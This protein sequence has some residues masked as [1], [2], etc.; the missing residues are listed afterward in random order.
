MGDSCRLSLFSLIYSSNKVRVVKPTQAML[1]IMIIT[2]C[3]LS[4]L[5]HPSRV[6][7]LATFHNRQ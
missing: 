4:V 7:H 6:I 3:T 5:M 2:I 1:L